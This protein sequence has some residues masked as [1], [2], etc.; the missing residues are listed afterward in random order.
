MQNHAWE[1]RCIARRAGAVSSYHGVM[2]L[3]RSSSSRRADGVLVSVIEGTVDAAVADEVLAQF[4]AHREPPPRAWIVDTRP[5]L[6]Y[7]AD[8]IAGGTKV[9]VEVRKHHAGA[10]V[11]IATSPVMR[12]AATTVSLASG[13][14][15]KCVDSDAAAEA[16]VA[17][18][19]ARS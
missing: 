12:M 3:G 1:R 7:T 17:D 9:I 10:I 5:T 2:A 8:G 19:P 15:L 16:I 18:L 11:V 13:G 4:Q 6:G 14:R